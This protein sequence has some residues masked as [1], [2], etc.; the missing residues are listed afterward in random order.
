MIRTLDDLDC[1]GVAVG[2]RIDINSPLSESGLADDARLRAHVETLSELLE[3][4][5]RVALL[6]HQGRPGDD[7]FSTLS[8][9]ADRLDELLSAPVDYCD[10]TF[11]TAARER[12]AELAAGEAVLLENTR[13]Y[14][15]EY[16][17][18]DPERAADTHLVRGLEPALDVYVNDAFAAAHRSQ[19]SL[20]GFPQRLPG[21]A[22]RVMERE[23]DVLGAIE[24]TPRPRVY[25]LGGAKVGDSIGVAR[26]V[27]E[28]DLADV[29]LTAGL[30]G[31]VC[32]LASGAELGTASA[33]FV[34]DQGYWDEIDRAGELLD[35]ADELRVPKDVAI[36]RDGERHEIPVSDLP[37]ETESPAMDV[38]SET[39]ESYADVIDSA[40][41]V[42]LNGPAGV[43]EEEIFA[44][45]THDLYSTAS[46]A[47]YSIVGGGDTAA[48]IRQL[49][50]EGFDHVSTG[51]GAS[52]A[53]LAGDS[54][55]AVEALGE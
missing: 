38:G 8:A 53:L 45:G 47:A 31:N 15:E 52:L 13:F 33:E 30:V 3:R 26:S 5:G 22:G 37:Q 14:A 19:P 25:L 48:A 54:L 32:L 17:E 55:P 44:R 50:I 9:H 18:F 27:I 40:G 2:V 49:E 51:G 36:E 11:S 43:F 21:Y 24:D 10:A 35:T 46:E 41:T 7:D 28:R 16:M 6:A 20:V 12:V 4:G 29:V 42:I 1:E 34:Y 23:L 39:I